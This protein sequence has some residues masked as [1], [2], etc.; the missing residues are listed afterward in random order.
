MKR[1]GLLVLLLLLVTLPAVYYG[2]GLDR[3]LTLDALKS[4]RATLAGWVEAHPV[5]APTAYFLLYVA[6]TA[7]SVPGAVLLTLA[8]G[9][10]FGVWFGTL[11][12]SFA[13][14][15]GA[16][17]SF[18]AARW[19]FRD[20]LRARFGTRLAS[21]E[22]GWRRDG[23]VYLLSLRLTP[24]VPFVLVNLLLGLSPVRVTTFAWVSQLGMLPATFAFVYAGTQLARLQSLSDIASPSLL[25]TLAALGIAPLLLRAFGNA[26]VVRRRYRGHRRP[27]RFD[28]N[29]VVIG[30]GSAGLVSAYIGAAVK[31]RVALIERAEMGG[32]CLNTGCVPSKALIRTA[33]LLAEARD[34]RRYGIRGMQ[35][36]LDF[37]EVMERVQRVVQAVAPHDSVER[38]SAMGVE[39]IRGAARLLSPWEVEVD[40]R[41]LSARSI[42]LATGAR[43]TL[44]DL[45]GLDGIAVLNSATL[46]SLRAL[47]A[48]LLVLGGGPIG[49]ELGLAFARMGSQVSVLSRSPRLL[50]REDPEA[51][52]LLHAVFAREGVQLLLGHQAARVEPAADG[53]AG[54]LVARG[55]DGEV[56][57]GFDRLLVA[58]GRTP[59]TAD[60]GLEA[61]GITLDEEHGTVAADG[62]L[63]TSLPNIAVCGDVAGPYQFTHVAAHQAWYAVVNQLLAPFWSFR[64]DYRV[65]PSVTFTDPQV[66]RVGLTEAE[67][68]ARGIAFEVTR[69]ALDDLDR[70]LTDDSAEG[71]VK[72]LTVPGRDRILGATI[73]HAE[74]GELIAE[75]VL[76]M[77]QRIGL[78]RI[79]GTL[80]AYPTLMEANK[81]T[82]GAWKRA[83]A[84]ARLLR[85]A[86]RFLRWRRG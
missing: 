48:R 30:A 8:G 16:T 49:C 10:L 43:P 81:Y 72:V 44:P 78:N 41:R 18:L 71:F 4:G 12:V 60:L 37:A 35:V 75:Y 15:L 84:P 46:W 56:R 54:T 34:S 53:H 14:T 59:N 1:S 70:A 36:T 6:A 24:L 77:Q 26:L 68:R 85:W 27:A 83:H 39:C 29:L 31:A 55:E 28:Y 62:L 66:A 69:F 76:A 19:L 64:V 21:L 25:L 7:L 73:V 20:A 33:R 61:L 47:P 23:T 58:V 80:H 5:A 42:I 11:L 51:A 50:P 38:Y 13:S 65:I 17:L 57:I 22:A 79:L 3:Q 63:R 82:A 52:A 32:D 74:A 67:A 86:E 9:A 45:P 2:F 40:G